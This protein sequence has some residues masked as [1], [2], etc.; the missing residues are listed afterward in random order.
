[1]KI[2]AYVL[3]MEHP[4]RFGLRISGHGQ[5]EMSYLKVIALPEM[6]DSQVLRLLLDNISDLLERLKTAGATVNV[7]LDDPPEGFRGG[8][9]PVRFGGGDDEFLLGSINRLKGLLAS[10][11]DLRFK[12][13]PNGASMI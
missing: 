2:E 10:P 6:T 11:K 12:R 4:G 7:H 5:R 1:M 13:S 3:F 9:K 8:Y